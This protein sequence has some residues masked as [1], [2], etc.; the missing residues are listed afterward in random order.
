MTSPKTA[1]TEPEGE[2]GTPIAS[3]PGEAA[4][5]FQT[6]HSPA[7]GFEISFVGHNQ[8]LL[9]RVKIPGCLAYCKVL[10]CMLF[11]LGVCVCSGPQYKIRFSLE[12][13]VEGLKTIAGESDASVTRLGDRQAQKVRFCIFSG[14]ES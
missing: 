13:I 8:N 14:C 12:V 2:A 9:N 11:G 6:E 1:L 7:E 10:F 3:P 4:P 5:G